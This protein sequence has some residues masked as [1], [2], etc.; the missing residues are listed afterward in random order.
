M[1]FDR[2]PSSYAVT[3]KRVQR[4]AQAFGASALEIMLVVTFL[5]LLLLL[6]YVSSVM[7]SQAA[8]PPEDET[9]PESQ[10]PVKP[11][12]TPQDMASLQRQLDSALAKVSDQDRVIE[13]L[14]DQIEDALGG[15]DPPDG[16][17]WPPIIRLDEADGYSF[18]TNSS[19]V[20]L[21]FENLLHAQVVP[22]IV[23]IGARFGTYT[24]EIVGHTDERPV[25]S[26]STLD[27]ELLPFLNGD[28]DAALVA[29]DNAGLGFA[30]AAA[31][32]QILSESQALREFRLIPLS[33]AQIVLRNGTI[34]DGSTSGDLP[35]RRR[36]EIRLRRSDNST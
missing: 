23:K 28:P 36:I 10:S 8:P 18:E 4:N 24:V 7:P 13:G 2:H 17:Q 27:E 20:R 16:H 29:A 1:G 25:F 15:E 12:P 33:G 30:R 26:A 14:E 11:N 9:P 6:A 21:D 19:E 22:E 3:V 35:G 5:I 31:V 32:A 34:S